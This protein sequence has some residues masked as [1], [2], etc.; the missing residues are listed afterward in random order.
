MIVF[1][2]FFLVH[3]LVYLQLFTNFSKTKIYLNLHYSISCNICTDETYKNCKTCPN[4]IKFYPNNYESLNSPEILMSDL[5]QF[6]YYKLKVRLF[7]IKHFLVTLIHHCC[8]VYRQTLGTL[9]FKTLKNLTS[10]LT[11]FKYIL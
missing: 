3:L 8:Q 2:Q 6:S 7:F 11:H 1:Y 9:L 5:L 4:S 10:L